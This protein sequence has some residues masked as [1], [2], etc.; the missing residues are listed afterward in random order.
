MFSRKL[1]L[2]KHLREE[3]MVPELDRADSAW[4]GEGR[5]GLSWQDVWKTS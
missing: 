1:F 5:T 2:D 3:E 4:V